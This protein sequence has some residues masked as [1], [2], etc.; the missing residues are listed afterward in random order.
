MANKSVLMSAI[1][2][3]EKAN[4]SLRHKI[5]V[6]KMNDAETQKIFDQIQKNES[7]ILDYKFRIEYE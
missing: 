6:E 2:L 7:M 1:D 3:L 4:A 5:A